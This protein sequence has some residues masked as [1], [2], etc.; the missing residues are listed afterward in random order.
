MMLMILASMSSVFMPVNLPVGER[1]E[2]RVS[3]NLPLH[4]PSATSETLEKNDLL[5]SL[6]SSFA[7]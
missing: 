7:S 3:M 4:L 1:F 5:L 6:L 2:R